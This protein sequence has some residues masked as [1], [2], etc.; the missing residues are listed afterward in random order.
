MGICWGLLLLNPVAN[1]QTNTAIAG[2]SPII[3]NTSTHSGSIFQPASIAGKKIRLTSWYG[4]KISR[5]LQGF[6]PSQVVFSP[7][8]WN[9]QNRMFVDP[10]V[11]CTHTTKPPPTITWPSIHGPWHVASQPPPV[12]PPVDPCAS[13]R[14]FCVFTGGKGLK[15]PFWMTWIWVKFSGYSQPTLT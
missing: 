5:Y 10:R 4:K 15:D 8:F 13:S 12:H 14:R 2:I 1:C 9:H 6:I 7:D 11:V 3:G